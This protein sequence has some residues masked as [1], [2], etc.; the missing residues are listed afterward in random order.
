MKWIN[1]L[2]LFILPGFFLTIPIC[3]NAQQNIEILIPNGPDKETEIPR[4]LE[5]SVQEKSRAD[6]SDEIVSWFTENAWLD[7]QIDSVITGTSSEKWYVN[8]G[9]RY[10]VASVQEVVIPDTLDFSDSVFETAAEGQ[11]FTKE[12]IEQY[13]SRKLKQ[14]EERGYLLARIEI[15]KV[16]RL[17]SDCSVNLDI[18]ISAG[19]RFNLSGILF[20]GTERNNPLFL[21]RIAMVSNGSPI[22][23][24]LMERARQNLLNSDLLISAEEADL[25]FQD[26][27]AFLRF[28]VEEQQLNFFDGIIG[29]VPDDNGTAQIVGNADLRLRNMITDGTNLQIRF[30]QL[31]PL[32]TKLFIEGE[33]QFI[34]GLPLRASGSLHFTQQDSAYLERNFRFGSGFMILPG[35]EL[36]GS[37]RT[38]TSSVSDQVRREAVNLDSRATFLG[39]GFRLRNVDRLLV[40]TSGYQ[41]RA[42]LESGRRFITDDRLDESK[43]DN[44]SQTILTTEGRAFFKVGSRQ[45]LTPGFEGYFIDSPSFI[46]TDLHRFGGTKSIRGFREDQFRASSVLWSD[47]EFRQL[48]SPDSYIFGFGSYGRFKRPQLINEDTDQFELTKS[49]Q[50]FGFGIAFQTAIGFLKV[51][52]AISTEDQ[53]SNG[54]VHVGISTGL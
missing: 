3:S 28:R 12:N 14:F 10:A 32:V 11:F 48:L 4:S 39:F 43:E 13:I 26:E 21:E 34:A 8:S 41:F 2:F 20:S 54:K 27:K 9:C 19:E 30:E 7:V 46:I 40:P 53:L 49:I 51:S 33:Q 29:F 5:L 42:L 6:A 16:T 1:R 24:R 37:I 36:L 50:S 44:F 31:R 35:F 47:L 18:Q 15:T 25:V 38:E 22:T 45:V 23:P 17:E 52:Y